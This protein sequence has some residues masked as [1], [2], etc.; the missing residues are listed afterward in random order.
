MPVE[1]ADTLTSLA[2]SISD[3]TGNQQLS[4]SGI[5]GQLITITLPHGTAGAA[6]QLQV[7]YRD[8]S[9]FSFNSFLVYILVIVVSGV[10]VRKNYAQVQYKLV[11]KFR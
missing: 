9:Y 5:P 11:T 6:N 2:E 10:F 7:S 3:T 8:G 1:Q 4:V